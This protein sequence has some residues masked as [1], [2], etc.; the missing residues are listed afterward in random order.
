M[1]PLSTLVTKTHDIDI[2]LIWKQLYVILSIFLTVKNS[3]IQQILIYHFCHTC[4]YIAGYMYDILW[5][6]ITEFKFAPV[7][8]PIFSSDSCECHIRIQIPL[9]LGHHQPASETPFK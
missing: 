1:G 7:H 5:Q 2:P 8:R 9:I 4:L 3:N 6:R